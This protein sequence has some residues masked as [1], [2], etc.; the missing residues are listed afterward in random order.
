MNPA[1]IKD[2]QDLPDHY[3]IT[4][5]YVTG[6]AEAFDIASHS[7]LLEGN[8]IE[9]VTK[10][11]LWNVIPVSNFIRLEFDRNYSKIVEIKEKMRRE[12]EEKKKINEHNPRH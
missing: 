6:K 2:H 11:N 5:H 7:W 9:Y 10:D 12:E 1:L 8:A 4:I 3:G